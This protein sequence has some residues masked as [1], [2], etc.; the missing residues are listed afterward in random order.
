MFVR[1]LNTCVCT[2]TLGWCKSRLKA[3]V[4][5]RLVLPLVYFSDG[6]DFNDVG[7]LQLRVTAARPGTVNFELDIK[8][9][10]TVCRS[11]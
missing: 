9:M 5:Y 4:S 8:Q 7:V 2:Q 11:Y 1:P 10:H 3:D 6:T